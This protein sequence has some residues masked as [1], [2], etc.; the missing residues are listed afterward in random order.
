ME[1][2]IALARPGTSEISCLASATSSDS[3]VAFSPARSPAMLSEIFVAIFPSSTLPTVSAV[4]SRVEPSVCK[5][6]PSSSSLI[7][8]LGIFLTS[9]FTCF[10]KAA[11]F[12]SILAP[13][14]SKFS[15]LFKAL[16]VLSANAS[17][18]L[19]RPGKNDAAPM[20]S[21]KSAEPGNELKSLITRS[22][23]T[24][25]LPSMVIRLP[26]VSSV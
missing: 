26:S 13:A 20:F 1:T 5:R 8:E 18:A 12:L 9:A 7:T 3:A 4:A 22:S 15:A 2:P 16:K 17:I 21:A 6:N 25:I 14:S 24:P 23:A 10:L 19:C 11:K